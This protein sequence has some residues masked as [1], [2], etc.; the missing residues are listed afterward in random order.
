MLKRRIANL[1]VIAVVTGAG[2]LVAPLTASASTASPQATAI[3]YATGYGSTITEAKAD[4]YDL[5]RS[6]FYGCGAPVLVASGSVGD[7]TLWAEIKAS[8]NDN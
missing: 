5:L 3:E 6:E 7:G 1:A 2:S 8:C 4:A